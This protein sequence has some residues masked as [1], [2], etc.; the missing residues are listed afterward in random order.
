[1]PTTKPKLT[2]A[3]VVTLRGLASTFKMD[4]PT[5][6]S[7]LASH[8]RPTIDEAVVAEAKRHNR[9]IVE[10][11]DSY[12]AGQPCPFRVKHRGYEV[13][14]SPA[15]VATLRERDGA[16][17]HRF[18]GCHHTVVRKAWRLATE[19]EIGI[20]T[21]ARLTYRMQEDKSMVA[22]VNGRPAV[23]IKGTAMYVAVGF[24]A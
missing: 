7:A 19:E 6:A 11:A 10:N 22:E 18:H 16:T 15:F 9:A 24:A 8:D 5:M 14:G 21:G 13:C 12:T 23:R 2:A 1:M 4:L 17:V 3:Q 20:I